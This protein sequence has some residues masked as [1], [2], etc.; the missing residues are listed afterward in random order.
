[1]NDMCMKNKK[2]KRNLK[3]EVLLG[4]LALAVIAGLGTALHAASIKNADK[5]LSGETFDPFTLQSLSVTESVSGSRSTELPSGIRKIR[6]PFVPL[7]PE[8]PISLSPFQP[9]QPD[10]LQ[11]SRPISHIPFQP[12]L[13]PR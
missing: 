2:G 10:S 12:V 4:A 1:M 9:E 5:S 6:V 11:P 8:R 13:A 7:I 3:S